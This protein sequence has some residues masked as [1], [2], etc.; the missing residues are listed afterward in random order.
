[1][2]KNDAKR[3]SVI[4]VH[5]TYPLDAVS[6]MPF[7]K[8]TSLHILYHHSLFERY[9]IVKQ[10]YLIAHLKINHE[11][12]CNENCSELNRKQYVTFKME[13]VVKLIS[14]NQPLVDATRNSVLCV[15][16]VL[17]LSLK[18]YNVF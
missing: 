2:F 5:F 4:F 8:I 16:V 6:R 10:P 13:L 12:G 7:P 15:G 14:S 9:I 17:D 1:M 3:K 11:P 18:Q